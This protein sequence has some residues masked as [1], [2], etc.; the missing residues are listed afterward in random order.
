M[1]AWLRPCSLPTLRHQRERAQV[2][3]CDRCPGRGRYSCAGR[4]QPQGV[5]HA[6]NAS[7]PRAPSAPGARCALRSRGGRCVEIEHQC[8]RPRRCSNSLTSS[9]SWRARAFQ[10]IDRARIRGMVVAQHGE[11]V[12]AAARTGCLGGGAVRAAAG[13]R[14]LRGV[15]R[16][17]AENPDSASS[18]PGTAEWIVAVADGCGPGRCQPRCC[19]GNAD[20]TCGCRW[21]SSRSNAASSSLDA[22]TQAADAVA[23]S[24]RQG[25][26]DVQVFAARGSGAAL[27]RAARRR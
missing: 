15:D 26:C 1:S 6:G 21:P 10:A 27:M 2:H 16:P 8:S 13:G 9:V 3:G 22:Q 4:A 18:R 25:R 14:R 20:A 23:R 17:S 5:A 11:F 24:A 19:V 7:R 12:A